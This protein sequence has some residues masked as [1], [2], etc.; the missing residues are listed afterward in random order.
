MRSVDG[1][2]LFTEVPKKLPTGEAVKVETQCKRCFI[3]I[4]DLIAFRGRAAL[5]A[6][7]VGP[8]SKI[9]PNCKYATCIADHN[10]SK[11]S[12]GLRLIPDAE[13]KTRIKTTNPWD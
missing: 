2:Q 7:L 10:F 13:D 1:S 3:V 9:I 6:D 11:E 4:A 5:S 8:H 12:P